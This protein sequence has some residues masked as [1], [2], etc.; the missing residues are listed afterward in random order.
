MTQGSFEEVLF[1]TVFQQRVVHRVGPNLYTKYVRNVR[2]MK[3]MSIKEIQEYK[4]LLVDLDGL[5]VLLQLSAVSPHL[6]QTL[7]GRTNDNHKYNMHR[8]KCVA[9][10]HLSSLVKAPPH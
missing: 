2:K 3:S 10:V 7:V 8:S 5:L 6:Q 4:Y 1:G 9:L